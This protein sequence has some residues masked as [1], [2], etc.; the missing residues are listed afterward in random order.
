MPPLTAHPP[1]ATPLRSLYVYYRVA[2]DQRAAAFQSI[3]E[4]Q[5]CLQQRH[6]GLRVTL[7][8]RA[9]MQGGDPHVTWMEVYDHPDGVSQACE[10]GLQALVAALPAGLIGERHVEMFCPLAAGPA[11]PAR[12]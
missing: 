6:P 8:Q 11:V 7:M 4:M 5:T 12:R 2:D 10:A 3:T 1:R 9:D